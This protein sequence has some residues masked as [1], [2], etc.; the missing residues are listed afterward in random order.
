[1]TLPEPPPIL[2][3]KEAKAFLEDIAK[4]LTEKQMQII[5]RALKEHYNAWEKLSAEALKN[6]EKRFD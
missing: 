4:P 2:R 6:F 1:M 5:T 3:G